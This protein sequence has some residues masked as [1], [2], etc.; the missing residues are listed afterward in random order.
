MRILN[1]LFVIFLVKR[2][3]RNPTIVER[4]NVASRYQRRFL[5]R[6]FLKKIRSGQ[7]ISNF[8]P[9]PLFLKRSVNMLHLQQLLKKQIHYVRFPKMQ[10]FKT[11][12]MSPQ[13]IKEMQKI[14]EMNYLSRKNFGLLITC[15]GGYFI[16]MHLS[17]NIDTEGFIMNLEI[18]HEIMGRIIFYN[19]VP[20]N[21]CS[22]E[23][24]VYIFLQML[25]NY[26]FKF[27][28]TDKFQFSFFEL[29]FVEYINLTIE[30]L[31][32]YQSS[33]INLPVCSNKLSRKRKCCQKASLGM[34]K[35]FCCFESLLEEM[36][37]MC[38]DN[39]TCIS[40][41]MKKLCLAPHA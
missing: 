1:S 7:N 5:R 23:V 38:P 13:I 30:I 33:L 34:N 26:Y 18:F 9:H 12:I 2:L 11:V 20:V 10:P 31:T 32:F 4:S 17:P 21:L 14:F 41:S 15:A 35:R 28:Y 29:G 40:K 8:Y 27:F 25:E 16:K 39:S 3:I 22:R 37:A 6:L 36:N 24:N 19:N